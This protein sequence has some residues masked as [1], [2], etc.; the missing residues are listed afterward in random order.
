M[1]TLVYNGALGV[2]DTLKIMILDLP[3]KSFVAD[4]AN[5]AQSID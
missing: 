4:H 2:Q 5:Y 3:Q 1:P